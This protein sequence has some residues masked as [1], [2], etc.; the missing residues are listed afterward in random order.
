M[1]DNEYMF[2]RRYHVRTCGLC[3]LWRFEQL[4]VSAYKVVGRGDDARDLC[5]D[6]ALVARN[7]ALAR[8][9]ADE[10]SYLARMEGPRDPETLCGNRGLSCYYPEVARIWAQGRDEA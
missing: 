5:A 8:T 4:G 2:N 1:W 6:A 7:A 10:E 3:A 9:C